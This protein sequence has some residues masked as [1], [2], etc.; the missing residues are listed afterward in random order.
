[1]GYLIYQR[2][3][4]LIKGIVPNVHIKD[5]WGS[6]KVSVR[7]PGI[8][9][10]T[11][12][13]EREAQQLFNRK[14]EQCG[15]NCEMS[16]GIHYQQSVQVKVSQ[17]L[18]PLTLPKVSSHETMART[19]HLLEIADLIHVSSQNTCRYDLHIIHFVLFVKLGSV[20]AV[21]SL[22]MTSLSV[23]CHWIRY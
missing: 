15:C 2:L 10:E 1:M 14:T 7:L 19:R 6:L 8:E 4:S 16:A 11:S 13:T 21:Y 18:Q 9:P 12:R 22:S 17:L 5:L 20:R 23:N 3:L